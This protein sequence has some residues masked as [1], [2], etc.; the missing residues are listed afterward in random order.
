MAC[1]ISK[2][3]SL[4]IL[5]TWPTWPSSS[6]SRLRWALTMESRIY[7]IQL[8]LQSIPASLEQ[9]ENTFIVLSLS[10]IS[11]KQRTEKRGAHMYKIRHKP[12]V[13][14]PQWVPT[15]DRI[16]GNKNKAC[17]FA[18]CIYIASTYIFTF[19]PQVC[20][21]MHLGSRKQNFLFNCTF[22]YVKIF[23]CFV[24]NFM[25]AYKFVFTYI[26]ARGNESEVKWSLEVPKNF[27]EY[28]VGAENVCKRANDA[29]QLMV[30]NC[31]LS[32]CKYLMKSF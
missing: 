2:Y 17:C 25:L 7:T 22:G 31:Y 20:V 11:C 8:A 18:I 16:E 27:S 5:L 13:N 9:W 15:M 4:P 28:F 19:H 32:F 10:A 30:I 26:V 23:W 14:K 24:R 6:N 29:I 3:M 12:T 1:D 21:N